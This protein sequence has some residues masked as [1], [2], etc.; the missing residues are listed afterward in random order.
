MG[1][2]YDSLSD[3]LSQ[4]LQFF[5]SLLD[6]FIQGLVFDLELLKIDEMQAVSKLLSFLEDLLLIR[7]TVTQSDVLQSVLMHFLV[8]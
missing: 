7:E 4:F 1:Q 6:F 5:V 2:D 3:L 8:L